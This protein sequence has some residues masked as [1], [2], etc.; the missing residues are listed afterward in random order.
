M[1][2]GPAIHIILG[3]LYLPFAL[4]QVPQFLVHTGIIAKKLRLLPVETIYPLVFDVPIPQFT[5][6]S[7]QNTH[8]DIDQLIST[9][10]YR[11]ITELLTFNQEN[12]QNSDKFEWHTTTDK[13]NRLP[14]GLEFLG[15]IFSWCCDLTTHAE[16][17]PTGQKV[18]DN[19]RKLNS[20]ITAG[21]LQIS[22]NNQ[23]ITEFAGKIKNYI[24]NTTS[25]FKSILAGMTT[26]HDSTVMKHILLIYNFILRIQGHEL[27]SANVS[28]L[29]NLH[30]ACTQKQLDPSVIP[31]NK[32]R[33]ALE[34]LEKDA[35]T[36]GFTLAIPLNNIDIYYHS[37]LAFCEKSENEVTVHAKIPLRSLHISWEIFE[38]TPI[39]FAFKETTCELTIE[40]KIAVGIS[41]STDRTRFYHGVQQNPKNSLAVISDFPLPPAT[42][43]CANAILS[44]FTTL[45]T[46]KKVCTFNCRSESEL[47]IVRIDERRYMIT[48]ARNLT[49]T[50]ESPQG[51]IHT[52]TGDPSI[53]EGAVLIDLPCNCTLREKGVTIINKKFPCLLESHKLAHLH[54]IPHQWTHLPNSIFV[55][56]FTNIPNLTNLLNEN[57]ETGMPHLHALED[58]KVDSFDW[59]LLQ[60]FSSFGSLVGYINL[61]LVL[62]LVLKNPWLICGRPAANTIVVPMPPPLPQ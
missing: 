6:F 56:Q 40:R 34:I 57:W 39:K 45:E 14:R 24:E 41:N 37:E 23:H 3:I 53:K 12:L 48:N 32:L 60:V 44:P 11:N 54:I 2:W 31:H 36:Q 15:S 9:D 33:M 16:L 13:L 10:A 61:G 22:T 50:C 28:N 30:S 55:A 26:Y 35:V 38:L 58:P 17:P 59:S 49:T 52:Q 21:F 62:F 20:Q 29:K 42:S 46:L 27:N 7:L 5:N 18:R 47:A 43:N 25:H 4:S 51:S 8:N 1:D 19:L